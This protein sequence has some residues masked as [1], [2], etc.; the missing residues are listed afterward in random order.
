MQERKSVK[1]ITFVTNVVIDEKIKA[2]SPRM[3]PENREGVPAGFDF[4]RGSLLCTQK[5]NKIKDFCASSVRLAASARLNRLPAEY[6]KLFIALY[7]TS[8]C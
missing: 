7:G 2:S 5:H 1:M 8:V 4:V 3:R 6:E